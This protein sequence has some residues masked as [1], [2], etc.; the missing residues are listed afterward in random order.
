MRASIT[1]SPDD[2]VSGQ[3]VAAAVARDGE[4]KGPQL[5][6][7][8]PFSN[9]VAVGSIVSQAPK[10]GSLARGATITFTVSK[11]P[12]YT[13]VPGVRGFNEADA[14]AKLV[15][16]GFQVEVKRESWFGNLAL[17]TDPG[18][19]KKAKTGSVVVLSIG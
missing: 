10:S 5:L 13:V 9:K 19:G 2:R 11:G 15:A 8:L 7:S 12:E 4:D 17:G 3:I 1:V 16:A 6:N 18:E 14:T